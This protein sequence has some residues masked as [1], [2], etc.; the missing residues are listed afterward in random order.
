MKEQSANHAGARLRVPG[1][2]TAHEVRLLTRT[3]GGGVYH[4]MVVAYGCPA[5]AAARLQRPAGIVDP[6]MRTRLLQDVAAS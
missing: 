2:R 3:G 5:A 4:Y 1:N 6:A